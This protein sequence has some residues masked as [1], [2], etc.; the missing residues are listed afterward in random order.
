VH[1]AHPILLTATSQTAVYPTKLAKFTPGLVLAALCFLPMEASAAPAYACSIAEIFESFGA[2]SA[3]V[4]ARKAPRLG[5]RI[6]KH[7]TASTQAK[8]LFRL[9][10]N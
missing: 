9:L 6:V 1:P 2:P 5:V 3:S 4:S 7:A 10:P 8:K